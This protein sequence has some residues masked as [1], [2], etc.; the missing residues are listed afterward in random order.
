[1][2]SEHNS[3][4]PISTASENFRQFPVET[5]GF[6]PWI[7]LPRFDGSN[8]KLWQTGCEDYFRFWNTPQSQWVSFASSLFDGP[9]AHW[10]ES[11]QHR[12]PNASWSEFCSLLLSCFGRNKHQ[13]LLRQLF[14]IRQTSTVEEYVERFSELFDQLTAYEDHPNTVH[15]VT[16]FMEGLTPAVRMLVGIQQPLDLDSA[17]ALALLSDELT[18]SSI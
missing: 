14:H 4:R 2:Q 15:Y 16:R 12:A 1:M 6:G 13:N 11:V 3:P 8:P 9:T 10:L 17:Y 7:E 5:L 18:N